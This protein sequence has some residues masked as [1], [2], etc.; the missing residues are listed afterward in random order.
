MTPARVVEEE[1]GE[2]LAPILQHAQKLAAREL[3][4]H[5][6]F[7]QKGQTYPVYYGPRQN[8]HVIDDQ[9]TIDRDGQRL[10]ALVEFPTV[11]VTARSVSKVDAA[12]T[13]KIARRF[14]L[15]L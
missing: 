10:L 7:R 4:R 11:H 9:R 2:R 1:S 13:E 5:V 8:L 15:G 6:I 3:R 12:M 14:R